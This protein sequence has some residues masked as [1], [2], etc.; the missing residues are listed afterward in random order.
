MDTFS[1]SKYCPCP[2]PR[3]LFFLGIIEEDERK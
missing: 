3:A 2:Y 1:F